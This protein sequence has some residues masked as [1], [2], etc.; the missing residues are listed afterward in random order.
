MLG[1]TGFRVL[2]SHVSYLSLLVSNSLF[3][4]VVNH[5]LKVISDLHCYC[6]VLHTLVHLHQI[7]LGALQDDHLDEDI[8]SSSL[9][10][11]LLVNLDRSRLLQV[12]SLHWQEVWT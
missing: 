6:Q 12:W 11:G 2:S 4:I 9:V 3:Y 8:H 5:F 7:S 1:R 10:P